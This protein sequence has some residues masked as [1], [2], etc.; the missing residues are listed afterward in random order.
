MSAAFEPITGRYLNLTLLGKP[1]RLYVEEAGKGIPLLCLHTA[2][3]DARQFRGLMND[4]RITDHF[5]VIAFDMPWHGKS[6]PPEGWQREEYQLPS[7]DY[8]QHDR[9]GGRR[10][11]A[12]QARRDGLLDRRAHRAASRARASRALPRADRAGKRGAHRAVLRSVVAVPAGCARRRSL[13]RRGIGADRAD[14]S[15]EA[16]L[17]DA[18]AL[19][20][21]RARRLQRRSVL[22]HKGRRHPRPAGPD[23]HQE[24]PALSAHR[25]IRLFLHHRGHAR[26]RQ[27][28]GGARPSS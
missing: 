17:G 18:V 11:V 3:S 20:A 12:G 1:Q 25:R 15:G 8:V 6:S 26:S 5:R 22:L 19:H 27:A 9:R 21:E 23:R 24:V 14:R 10:A 7:R 16:S 4:R 28:H 13:R 2:G